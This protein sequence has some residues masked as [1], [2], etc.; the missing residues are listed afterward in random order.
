MQNKESN[1]N[2]NGPKCTKDIYCQFLVAAQE[3]FTAT[4]MEDGFTGSEAELSHD[5]VTR[6]QKNVK[7]TPAQ[8][9]PEVEPLVIK[10][11]GWLVIDDMTIEK[12][13]SY[14]LPMGAWHWSGARHQVVRGLNV[15]NLLWTGAGREHIP[16]DFRLYAK[17]ED[18]MTRNRHV[19]DMLRL[20]K[21]R[22]L[23]PQGVVF[24]TW[25]AS[26]ANLNLIHDLGWIWYAPLKPNRIVNY[27]Q[28][29]QDLVFTAAEL[30]NG[31]LCHLK[32]VGPV[33]VFKF[34][35][36]D[37]DI[38]YWVTNKLDASSQDTSEARVR[39]WSVEEFH[40]GLKQTTGIGKCQA[41]NN[42]AQ[43][44]HIFCSIRS[45]VILEYYRLNTGI[46]WYEAKRQIVR[47]AIR[48][49]LRQPLIPW[50]TAMGA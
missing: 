27:T 29:L 15:V 28:H 26:Q 34:I 6:W 17:R 32:L 9:W 5:A 35:A 41:R 43:R 38:E 11:S 16:V 23:N 25:Y 10:D 45:F 13:R 21:H 3:D 18:G 22:G 12:N 37:G 19:K 36:T 46:T 44:N 40:R 7:L 14:Q 42:R 2:K 48:G 4:G 33:K 20:A 47:E 1:K 30:A 49:Y 50:P 24:D 39:R 8:L 31:K